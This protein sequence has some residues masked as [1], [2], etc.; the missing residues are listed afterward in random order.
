MF[1]KH[2]ELGGFKAFGTEKTYKRNLW[3]RD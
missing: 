2:Y 3:L 1:N